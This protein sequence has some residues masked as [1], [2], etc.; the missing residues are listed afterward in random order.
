LVR[1][2]KVRARIFIAGLVQGVFFR[3]ETRRKARQLGVLGWVRNLRD[4]RVEVN[5]EGEEE[6][7]KRLID[8][9][10]CGPS[11]ANIANVRIIWERYVGKF[12]DFEVR[13]T[14]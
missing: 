14:A 3:S 6:A 2:V 13:F 1:Y 11:R 8:F 7:V 5:V 10:K 12:Q 4:G 9:C